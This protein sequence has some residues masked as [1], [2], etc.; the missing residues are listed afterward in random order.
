M[1][2]WD[3]SLMVILIAGISILSIL[4]L[5][6]TQ[7][8]TVNNEN[9]I[10]GLSIG[11]DKSDIVQE[12]PN[13]EAPISS[14]YKKEQNFPGYKYC[15]FVFDYDKEQYAKDLEWVFKEFC[16]SSNRYPQIKDFLYNEYKVEIIESNETFVTAW[17]A[18]NAKILINKKYQAPKNFD[19]YLAHEIAHSSVE[20]LNI[21]DW[22]N[23][24]IATYS[25]YRFFDTQ[26]KLTPSWRDDYYSFE[27]WSPL[28]A[29]YGVNILGYNHAGYV[30]KAFIDKYGEGTFKNLLL[31]LDGKIQY[32]DDIDTKNQKVLDAIRNVTNNQSIT[33]NEI[34]RPEKY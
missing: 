32:Y 10:S 31:E 26:S 9:P 21:P 14:L 12:T 20:T 8:T 6:Y 13:I 1:N 7:S 2:E 22:L 23:E 25:A 16:N 3:K 24:G 11:T 33:L 18:G 28:N 29:T 5:F 4:A 15:I 19:L 27:Y 34:I 17:Y 30:V